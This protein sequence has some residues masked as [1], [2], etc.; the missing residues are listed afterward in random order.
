M[1]I[2]AADNQIYIF[3]THLFVLSVE[4]F[5]LKWKRFMVGTKKGRVGLSETDF[6][7][8]FRLIVSDIVVL[9]TTQLVACKV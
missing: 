6:F 2:K 5:L 1:H 8:S 9:P 4:P 3:C 7:F